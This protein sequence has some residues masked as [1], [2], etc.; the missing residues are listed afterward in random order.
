MLLLLL[1][2]PLFEV[3]DELVLLHGE[4]LQFQ[5]FGV[6]LLVPALRFRQRVVKLLL[7]YDE[8]FHLLAVVVLQ[9]QLRHMLFLLE[10]FDFLLIE[11]G[12]LLQLHLQ[13]R[14]VLRQ[15]IDLR[16]F[17]LELQ[18]QTIVILR[19]AALPAGSSLPELFS[20]LALV[21]ILVLVLVFSQLLFIR[22][23]LFDLCRQ[24]LLQLGDY[25]L[26]VL[27]HQRHL[28]DG[29]QLDFEVLLLGHFL[30]GF[31]FVLLWHGHDLLL[32]LLLVLQRQLCLLPVQAVLLVLDEVF[33][34]ILL[35]LILFFLD[36]LDGLLDL[37]LVLD[38]QA[39]DVELVVVV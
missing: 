22:V 4:L 5:V 7:L 34:D 27:C 12:D 19:A 33:V 13:A 20:I 36:L 21:A 39:F 32:K 1:E 23:F 35:D 38:G 25:A 28:S 15:L 29:L 18:K 30:T 14:V 17:L 24:V 9:A 3:L 16:Q 11:E 8:L 37:L 10:L 2:L 26:V 6:E 31:M